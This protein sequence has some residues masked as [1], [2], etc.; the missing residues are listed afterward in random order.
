MWSSKRAAR[1][2]LVALAFL[3]PALTLAGCTSFAPV[4]SDAAMSEAKFAFNYAKP[5]SRLEQV[6]YQEL[7]L[8]F[9]EARRADAPTLA[10][11]ISAGGRGL[12]RSA[13][14]NPV[15]NYEASASGTVTIT[16]ASG[17]KLFA[18]TRNASTGYQTNGQVFADTEAFRAASEQAARDVA[19]SLRL[20]I[21]AGYKGPAPLAALK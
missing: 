4:Y 2:A 12:T 1:N 14:V 20:A 3:T 9:P 10:V 15:T 17:K 21:L 6:A 8:R 13:S 19:E 5:S 11:S 18:A 16:D 7:S